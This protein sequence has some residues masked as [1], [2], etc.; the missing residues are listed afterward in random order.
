MRISDWS[1]DVCS[2]DLQ[3][4]RAVAVIENSGADFV[5][6]DLIFYEQDRASF[7]YAGD[8]NYAAVIASRMPSLNHPTVLARRTAFERIGLF[9]PAS[10]ERRVGKEC[11][12]P[13]RSRWAPYH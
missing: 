7:R 3:L 4:G 6:G 8:A 10:E 5:F 1:S 2:S 11:V 13:C 9:D 12:S